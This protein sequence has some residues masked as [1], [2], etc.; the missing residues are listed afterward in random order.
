MF[1]IIVF[2]CCLT[3]TKHGLLKILLFVNFPPYSFCLPY[4]RFISIVQRGEWN[5]LMSDLRIHYLL[6]FDK[7]NECTIFFFFFLYLVKYIHMQAL[8][9]WCVYDTI[10][11]MLSFQL[12]CID[13]YTLAFR[14]LH[15]N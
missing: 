1:T 14:C 3:P 12:K 9:I 2:N 13:I 11:Y 6:V 10:T 8:N 5:C 4:E 15:S 7:E